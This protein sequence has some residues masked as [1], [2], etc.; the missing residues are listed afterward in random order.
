MKNFINMLKEYI[1]RIEDRLNE[2][3]NIQELD[4]IEQMTGVKLPK[5]FRTLYIKYNGEN[6]DPYTGLFLGFSFMNTEHILD[7]IKSFKEDD[8]SDMTSL[9]T[10]KVT[11]EKM[12]DRIMIPFAWDG[13]RG[14]FC[15]DMTPDTEGKIG[16]VIALDY[17]Y[18]ECTLLADDLDGFF[19]FVHKM[20]I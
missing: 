8:F 3:V 9:S 12:C 17:D 10:G 4:K 15:L 2:D 19:E 6:N 13:S 11:D 14:F 20:L 1:P 7:T 5:Y 16:Q 18:N